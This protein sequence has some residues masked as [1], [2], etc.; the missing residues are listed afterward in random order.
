LSEEQ[1]LKPIKNR[2]AIFAKFLE[3]SKENFFAN[4]KNP[5]EVAELMEQIIS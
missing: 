2:P 3:G 1:I 5:I 4:K